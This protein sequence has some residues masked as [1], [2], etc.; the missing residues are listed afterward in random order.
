LLE[1]P[2]TAEVE[3]HSAQNACPSS[4]ELNV[5]TYVLNGMAKGDEKD[6]IQTDLRLRYAQISRIGDYSSPVPD[7]L[8]AEQNCRFPFINFKTQP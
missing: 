5:E 3:T 8:T 1:T 6:P 2:L 7:L 4:I